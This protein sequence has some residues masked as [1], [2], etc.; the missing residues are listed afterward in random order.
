MEQDNAV[1]EAEPAAGDE[2]TMAQSADKLWANITLTAVAIFI[3]LAVPTSTRQ[4]AFIGFGVCVLW[5]VLLA[6]PQTRL[7]ASMPLLLIAGPAMLL[8]RARLT[9]HG[10]IQP[11]GDLAAELAEDHRTARTLLAEPFERV[12][13]R[14]IG[15]WRTSQFWL[16][17]PDPS[18]ATECIIELFEPVDRLIGTAAIIYPSTGGKAAKPVIEFV[19]EYTDGTAIMTSNSATPMLARPRPGRTRESFPT[20]DDADELRRLH[21][22]AL[23]RWGSAEPVRAAAPAG[24]ESELRGSFA[25]DYQWWAERRLVRAGAEPGTYRYTLKGAVLA[26]WGLT[27]GIIHVRQWRLRRRAERLRRE[28][29]G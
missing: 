9:E 2:P 18:T 7:L 16:S 14:P 21:E 24:W 13:W 15:A 12:D 29:E 5:F 28:L 1:V 20:I 22:L 6:L 19:I 17:G 3:T 11:L 8:R 27:P 25:R 10:Q 23:K 26:A 4:Y